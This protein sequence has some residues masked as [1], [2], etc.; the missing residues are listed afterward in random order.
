MN[1]GD[2]RHFLG[3][4]DAAAV[5]GVSSWTSPVELWQ[6][7]ALGKVKPVTEAQKRM[8]KRGTRLEPFIRGMVIEKLADEGHDVELVQCNGRYVDDRY[9]F[10]S[11]EIDFELRVDGEFVN[12][13]AKSVSGFARNKWG[14]I[15][16]DAMPIEYA[17]QFMHGLG[18][19]P[20][21]PR[22][23]LVAA[24]RSFDDVDIYWL[25]RDEETIAG[26]REKL[27]SFW[28]DH[29]LPKVPPDPSKFA[30]VRA[31]FPKA[32]PA[33]VE[34]TPEV[35]A[36]VAR[37]REISTEVAALTGEEE[38]IRFELARFMGPHAL[39]TSGVRN[40]LT[41]DN[42]PSKRFDLEAFKREHPDWVALYTKTTT[43]RVMRFGSKRG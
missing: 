14:E 2:R 36:K 32:K 8:R 18:I 16:T 21:K 9:P 41:W 13:D 4:S 10:L 12:G 24:L 25:T 29:V 15:G 34:A 40:V 27:V 7:K 20:L 35:L 39:L 30:D 22:R 26:M 38:R 3:G 17:A 5:L 33:S 1:A 23:T 43:S 42:Q 37:L 19:H 31:L 6:Q 11:C 28:I